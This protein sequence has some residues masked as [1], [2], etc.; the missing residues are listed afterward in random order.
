MPLIQ[1]QI[2]NLHGWLNMTQFADVVTMSEMTPGPI[3]VNA[4]TFVGTRIAGLPGGIIATFG[5]ILAPCMISLLLAYLYAR[6]C[7]IQT[8]QGILTGLRPAVVGLIASAGISITA[9][10]LWGGKITQ[11][12]AQQLNLIAIGLFAVA[13][14]S[15]LK[16][17]LN[18]II[19]ILSSGALG[20]LLYSI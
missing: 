19:I 6:Y 12:N 9:L 8:V 14:F 20:L 3:A 5:C 18:P 4:A 16:W 11:F 17:K 13:L 15:Y 1:E 7:T 10:A 2:V